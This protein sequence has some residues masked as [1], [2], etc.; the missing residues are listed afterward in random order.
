MLVEVASAAV[1]GAPYVAPAGRG[2]QRATVQISD[3]ADRPSPSSL[4]VI[5]PMIIVGLPTFMLMGVR[6]PVALLVAAF[7]P[8]LVLGLLLRAAPPG[9]ARQP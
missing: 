9:R 5:V 2:E 7:A 3:R 1:S 6:W 8:R 4:R